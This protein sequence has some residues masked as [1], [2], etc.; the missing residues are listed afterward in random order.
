MT[1]RI[2]ALFRVVVAVLSIGATGLGGPIDD[3]VARV[4]Q[5]TYRHYLDDLLYTHAGD[6]RQASPPT[7]DHDAA[8]AN[9]VATFNSFGLS[10]TLDPF[11]STYQNVIAVQPGRVHPDR[12]LIVGAH[13]DSAGT[14]GADDNASGTAGVLEAARVLSQ[15]AF[16]NTLVYIAF[17]AEERGLQGSWHYVSEH[18]NDNI[19]GMISLDMISLNNL[20][21][22][23]ANIC[24]EDHSA[25][26][27]QGLADAIAQYG[28]GAWVHQWPGAT[29][30]DHYPFEYNKI[31]ACL[32]IEDS[33][34]NEVYH[35]Q[36][37]SVDTPNLIDYDYATRLTRGTIGYLAT[38]AVPVPEP[39]TVLLVVALS[40]GLMR[41]RL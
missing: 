6:N 21:G 19:L 1:F 11:G 34:A 14:P 13:Y 17:D 41:K 27:K 9:I 25:A 31:P 4:D 23:H 20:G 36:N 24:G 7:A 37:D 15:Y 38:A 39:C 22:F 28:Q 40:A 3:I 5:A 10:V 16:E 32:L 12:I 35:T 2:T 29:R 8:R 26:L 18:L 30:S 33:W